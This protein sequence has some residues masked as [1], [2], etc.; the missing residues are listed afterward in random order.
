MGTGG[1]F[2]SRHERASQRLWV[3]SLPGWTPRRSAKTQ[4]KKYWRGA[5]GQRWPPF[6]GASSWQPYDQGRLPPTKTL[7]EHL[8]GTPS[9]A[10]TVGPLGRTNAFS[11]GRNPDRRPGLSPAKNLIHRPN[12]PVVLVT[13]ERKNRRSPHAMGSSAA[14]FRTAWR[15]SG[16]KVSVAVSKD[17]TF[18]G[19][20]G[21]V[22]NHRGFTQ[23]LEPL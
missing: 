19:G 5:L 12:G 2:P 7:V 16:P 9:H 21:P 17:T 11:V 13:S 15:R 6:A 20:R 22:G 3:R 4:R 14:P 1:D 18:A 10:G 23:P 8:D